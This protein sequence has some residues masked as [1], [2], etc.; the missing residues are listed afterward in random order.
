MVYNKRGISLCLS[1]H[2]YCYSLYLERSN[3]IRASGFCCAPASNPF[4][5]PRMCSSIH[6]HA[7]PFAQTLEVEA[8]RMIQSRS[9]DINALKK[10]QTE[11]KA[12]RNASWATAKETARANPSKRSRR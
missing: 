10:H 5:P 1:S 8:S 11:V 3:L 9:M 12:Y 6:R 2:G 4:N 7:P